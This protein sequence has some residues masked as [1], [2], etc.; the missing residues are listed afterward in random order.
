MPGHVPRLRTRFAHRRVQRAQEDSAQQQRQCR[1]PQAPAPQQHGRQPYR[2]R[3]ANQQ[4][5]FGKRQRLGQ[6]HAGNHRRG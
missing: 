3:E 6:H 2:Q 1:R 4:A 5:R